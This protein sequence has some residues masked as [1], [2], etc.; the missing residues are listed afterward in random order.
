MEFIERLKQTTGRLALPRHS[1]LNPKQKLLLHLGCAALA[2]MLAV[3]S[4]SFLRGIAAEN[5]VEKANVSGSD[6]VKS[7]NPAPEET[8]VSGSDIVSG[9]DRSVR[10]AQASAETVGPKPMNANIVD[11]GACGEGINW[12]LDADGVLTISGS[13][14]MSD[15][16]P[17]RTYS[18]HKDD[19]KRI[20]IENGVTTIGYMAFSS[21]SMLT[22]V[23][24]GNSVTSINAC[25]FESC[26]SL[27]DVHISDSVTSIGIRAFDSCSSLTAVNIPD[28]VTSIGALAFHSCTSLPSI[29]IPGSVTTVGQQAFLSCSQL[30]SATLSEGIQTL[31][32]S[33][34]S[35]TA[36]TSVTLPDSITSLGRS[37]F[38]SC[39]ELTSATLPGGM[40]SIPE[41]TFS[42][43]RALKTLTIGYVTSVGESALNYT[44]AL[45]TVY[46]PC[47]HDIA[48]MRDCFSDSIEFI[49]RHDLTHH[50]AVPATCTGAGTKEH[51]ECSLCNKRFRDDA[52]TQELINLTV[53]ALGHDWGN[54]T[55]I[56]ATDYS[57]ASVTLTC[58]RCGAEK[59]LTDNELH[60]VT[61]VSEPTCTE[62]KV[63]RYA[64]EVQD[65]E[66]D[67][68]FYGSTSSDVEV[69]DTSLGHDW[70]EWFTTT[71]ATC[72]APG[73]KTRT[74]KNDPSH[75]ETEE[76][77]A[78]THNWYAWTAVEGYPGLQEHDCANCGEHE[79]RIH[80][81]LQF[82]VAAGDGQTYTKGS[83]NPLAIKFDKKDIPDLRNVNVYQMFRNGGTIEVTDANGN[84][85]TL[86][87][88]DFSASEGSL[89]VTLSTEYLEGLEE[90]NYAMTVTFVV[91]PDYLMTGAPASFT[92]SSPAPAGSDS[93]A[94][95]ESAATPA[96][97][98]A[99]MMLAAYGVVYATRRRRAVSAKAVQ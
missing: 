57:S 35:G 20:I 38:S 79:T 9:S 96:T 67:S 89:D 32:D 80:P 65:D 64:A 34:F 16:M 90:G 18:S 2:V 85:T 37:V 78:L 8:S 62:N 66:N 51:W 27:P 91:A 98:V 26:S 56:W 19:I 58:G 22:D 94:T 71:P 28:S 81:F 55:W 33:V 14:A 40:T 25:A 46:Y 63:V 43:C 11:S 36:L 21:F 68:I 99:L 6:V 39:A 60:I 88:G 61:V 31:G 30:S 86:G 54:D 48:G 44:D 93:P 47:D 10:A 75:T 92:V 17:D 29:S 53:N 7:D 77:P 84:V 72:S 52:G 70:G 5:S 87:A 13:G 69:P 97:T 15:L 59:T 23:S 42:G 45:E 24:I 3:G 41:Y 73:E 12:T 83:Q 76:I 95:G 50:D 49:P 74:C 82:V 4:V 1:R